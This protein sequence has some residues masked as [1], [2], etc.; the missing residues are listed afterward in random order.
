MVYM[1]NY[2]GIRCPQG[3]FKFQRGIS[4][5]GYFNTNTLVGFDDEGYLG[6]NTPGGQCYM[7][8]PSALIP[9]GILPNIPR[10]HH[11]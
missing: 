4:A 10:D 5:E 8:C 6:P 11:V 1:P 3:Y 2:T 9:R 7:D